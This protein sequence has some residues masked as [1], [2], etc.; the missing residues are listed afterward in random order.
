M[1]RLLCARIMKDMITGAAA[2][3]AAAMTAEDNKQAIKKRVYRVT[4]SAKKLWGRKI[5]ITVL[6]M[7][8]IIAHRKKFVNRFL[9]IFLHL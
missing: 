9:T 5:V 7:V 3:T 8:M 1:T 2:N 4:L 6:S